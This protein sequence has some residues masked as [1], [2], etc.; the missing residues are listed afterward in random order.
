MKRFLAILCA[1]AMASLLFAGCGATEP[2]ADIPTTAATPADP[3]AELQLIVPGTLTVGTEIGY[4]PFEQFADDGTTPIGLDI[5][6]ATAI[7]GILGV[8]VVF[9]NTRFDGILDGLGIDKYDVVMSA[10]TITPERALKVD[11]SEPYIENWQ[12]I[13]VRKGDA[14]IASPEGLNG[15]KV[16]YQEATTSTAYLKKFIETGA[17]KCTI[18]EFEKVMDCFEDLKNSRVDAVLCDSVVA[19]DY[20]AQ[21]PDLYEISWVQSSV[22]G[23]EPELFGVGVKKGNAELLAAVNAALNELKANGEYEQICKDWGL[24]NSMVMG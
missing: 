7:A 21:Y 9:Q 16:S 4:P 11:F 6:L 24:N 12:A 18:A 1:L 15:K 20:V 5:D 23:D 8:N 19:D 17:V 2:P 3:P 14:P 22:E 13:V 10:V